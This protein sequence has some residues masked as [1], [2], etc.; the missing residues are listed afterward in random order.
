MGTKIIQTQFTNKASE[1]WKLEKEGGNYFLRNCGDL[2]LY[3][4]VNSLKENTNLHLM[5][6][7]DKERARWVL[8]G[9]LPLML[10]RWAVGGD[11]FEFFVFW[12]DF[13][14]K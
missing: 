14:F 5:G 7:K 2:D 10:K 9:V 12:D 11:F 3:M 1:K 8:E 6:E 13:F 4:G